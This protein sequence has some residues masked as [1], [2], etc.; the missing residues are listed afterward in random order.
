MKEIITW[1]KSLLTVYVEA[2]DREHEMLIAIMNKLY[3]RHGANAPA[4]ELGRLLKELG[5]FTV[6]HFADE[7][8]YM[9]S[10]GYAGLDT[11]KLIHAE[12]LK[13]FTKHAETFAKTKKLDEDF[14]LFLKMWLKA[15][16]QGID[17]RYGE[18]SK[19]PVAKRA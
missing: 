15:H 6:K 14:F 9:A 18:P 7:E 19:T 2:M 8:R 10:I 11:H 16:I 13:T 17:R 3:D 12:L 1:D 4:A 5:D